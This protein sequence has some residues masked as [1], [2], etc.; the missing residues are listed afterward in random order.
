[1]FTAKNPGEVK[2]PI[3]FTTDLG[4]KFTA[5]LTTYATVEAAPEAPT[6][7]D[8]SATSG[9]S[10]GSAATPPVAPGKVVSQ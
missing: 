2:V 6:A 4:E 7:K 8:S 10:A 1:V 5:T 9:E 3:V